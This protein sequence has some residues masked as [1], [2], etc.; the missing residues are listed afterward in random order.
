MKYVS[1]DIT[2]KLKAAREAKGLSQRELSKLAGVPQG[3][4]SKIE[5]GDVDLR[6]SSLVQL[7]RALGLELILVPRK[8]LP[9]I[10]SIARGSVNGMENFT[11]YV[12][13]I[14]K[15][16]KQIENTVTNLIRE[17][18]THKPLAQLQ[19]QVKDI[20]HMRIPDA[21]VEKIREIEKSLSSFQTH[22]EDLR[23]VEKALSALQ[24]MRNSVMHEWANS[25][26]VE[27]VQPA[28]SLDENDYG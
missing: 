6:V 14:Q 16:L 10:G 27:A 19:S 26:Q 9:V 20:Q 7:G 23:V 3:H 13:G 18:P 24:R 28:Y 5:N 2:E 21:Y 22:K 15:A 17:N 11:G 25:P 12:P 1:K 4:I 8:T